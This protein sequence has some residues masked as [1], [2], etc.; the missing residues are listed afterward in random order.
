MND[1]CQGKY[2]LAVALQ[3]RVPCKVKGKIIKGDLMI[4]AGN[5]YAE[6]SQNPLLGSLIGKALEDFDGEEGV[7]EVLVGLG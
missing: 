5:G 1:N 2:V 3:G 6:S 4:S 7:I